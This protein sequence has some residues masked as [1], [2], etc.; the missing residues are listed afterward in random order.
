M[1][2]NWY[3][4]HPAEQEEYELTVVTYLCD[5][6][7]GRYVG[8]GIMKLKKQ[9]RH[10]QLKY[11]DGLNGS[12]ELLSVSPP[13]WPHVAGPKLFTRKGCGGFRKYALWGLKINQ[14][15][16]EAVKVATNFVPRVF[17]C[18]P[19]PRE[20]MN[21]GKCLFIPLCAANCSMNYPISSH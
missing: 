5:G 19:E 1:T 7:G 2:A 9:P 16:G 17:R 4:L 10:G 14:S 15:S 12:L 13:N 11:Y 8:D 18:E 6:A 20:I 3:Q 21:Y